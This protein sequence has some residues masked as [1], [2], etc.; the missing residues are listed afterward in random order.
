MKQLKVL[1]LALAVFVFS[2]GFAHNNGTPGNTTGTPV[3]QV[4]NSNQVVH[5]NN[6]HVDLFASPFKNYRIENEVHCTVYVGVGDEM[7]TGHGTA[8][9]QAE[10]CRLAYIHA[11]SQRKK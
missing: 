7:Y 4:T 2:V 1:I 5:A 9:T 3:T 8:E 10:A 11:M 6:M